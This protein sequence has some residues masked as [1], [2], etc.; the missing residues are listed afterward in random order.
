MVRWGSDSGSA[1]SSA[2][3][4]ARSASSAPRRAPISS[5]RDAIPCAAAASS[6]A[7]Y[8]GDAARA[9]AAAVLGVLLPPALYQAGGIIGCPSRSDDSRG[10][11]GIRGIFF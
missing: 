3:S 10:Y 8:R 11:T 2:S 1:S 6:I 7:T 4:A 5:R 9:A